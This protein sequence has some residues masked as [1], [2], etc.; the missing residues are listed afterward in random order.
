LV[1]HFPKVA[2][3][4]ACDLTK[5]G[6]LG[7]HSIS[8]LKRGVLWHIDELG[9]IVVAA[10]RSP[11]HPDQ[12]LTMAQLMASWI[13]IRNPGTN[14]PV[15]IKEA[16]TFDTRGELNALKEAIALEYVIITSWWHLPR[17]RLI[18]WQ[19]FPRGTRLRGVADWWD[20]PTFRQLI[21][22]VPKYVHTM[23]PPSW[24]LKARAWWERWFG[25]SSW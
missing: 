4:L 13:K 15:I 2:L 24:R 11:Y 7:P 5:D 19:V 18:A 10:G 1:D 16:K 21:L 12:Q 8:R 25:R 23:L 22:E 20:R 6:Q 3:V 9:A 17:S 14:I